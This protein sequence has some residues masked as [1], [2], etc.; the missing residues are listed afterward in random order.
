MNN[1]TRKRVLLFA[2]AV[3][4]AHVARSVKLAEELTKT[5]K[6]AV[7]MAA[8]ARYDHLIGAVPWQRMPLFSI[9]SDFFLRKLATGQPMYS[10]D[11]LVRYVN[12]DIAAI[13]AFKP[14]FVIGDFRLSLALSCTLKKIPYATVTNAYWSPYLDMRYPVPE[15]PLVDLLGVKISDII[16][17]FIQPWAFKLHAVA[18]RRACKHFGIA[19]FASDMRETYTHADFT[20]YA[21]VQSLIPMKPLPNN[22]IFIGPV[23]WSTR[24]PLPVWWNAI[25][26]ENPIVFVTLGS[27]GESSLLPMI[28]K[29]LSTMPVTVM[30]VTADKAKLLHTY[31]NCFTAEFVPAE[32]AV[33]KADIVI[34]NGGSPMVYQTLIESK[35]IIGIPSNLDQYLMMA[36]LQ[37]AGRGQLIRAGL[38]K[39]NL[40]AE[41][42][43]VALS[44]KPLPLEDKPILAI[45]KITGLIDSL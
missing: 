41:A 12:D 32:Q 39:P 29:T 31:Q 35:A 43:G 38:A 4:L 14:D 11:T 9:S 44:E 24:A 23:L 26:K 7:G 25:P 27:S 37:K 15:N 17:Q 21:D 6:Y 10:L 16:F 20:L 42:V 28:L 2:E 40:I 13:E 45:D 8:D 34:C 3:T 22:H 33:K 5:G 19:S 18:F 36:A 1:Q 30:C